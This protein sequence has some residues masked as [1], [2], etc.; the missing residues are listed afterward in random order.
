MALWSVG[1]K[2]ACK[3]EAEHNSRYEPLGSHP[4]GLEPDQLDRG[5]F[6]RLTGGETSGGMPAAAP[7][8][9]L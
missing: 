1:R 5:C 7:T 2:R 8:R 9:R 4:F 3:I 6:R